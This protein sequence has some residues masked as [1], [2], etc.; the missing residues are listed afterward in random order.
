MQ[1]KPISLGSPSPARIMIKKL[2]ARTNKK[3]LQKCFNGRN[4]F[5]VN[6]IF[7]EN[8]HEKIHRKIQTND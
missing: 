3:C 5:S 4:D 6:E 8:G 1:I 2:F 7:L